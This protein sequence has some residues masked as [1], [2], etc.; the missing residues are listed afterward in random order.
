L[1]EKSAPELWMEAMQWWRVGCKHRARIMETAGRRGG[2]CG[3]AWRFISYSD[4]YVTYLC[5]LSESTLL[6]PTS[7]PVRIWV[8]WC[9]F[10]ANSC[11]AIRLIRGFGGS[12]PR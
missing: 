1:D 2:D 7:D 9:V 4:M 6:G 12:K 10:G 8:L 5:V 3:Q 11:G